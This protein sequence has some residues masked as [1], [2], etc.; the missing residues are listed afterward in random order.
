MNYKKLPIIPN[1]GYLKDRLKYLRKRNP[2]VTEELNLANASRC[3]FCDREL[4]VTIRDMNA[5]DGKYGRR[6]DCSEEPMTNP[7]IVRVH[8]HE[9][10]DIYESA[11]SGKSEGDQ[12]DVC[13]ICGDTWVSM[14]T[15][16]K[17][18]HNMEWE[19]FVS[20]TGYNGS[21]VKFS[22]HHR[23]TLSENKRQ[24]YKTD[25]GI[26]CKEENA[27]RGSDNPATR[28]EVRKKISESRLGKPCPI[29]A[30]EKNSVRLSDKLLN[31]ERCEF[32]YGYV[33][34]VLWGGRE[35]YSRSLVEFKVLFNLL[36][37][38]KEVEVEPCRIPYI[39]DGVTRN[40]VPDFKIGNEYFETKATKEEFESEKYE[41]IKKSG[42]NLR[43]LNNSS[44][45]EVIGEYPLDSNSFLK[46]LKNQILLGN[47]K[48][49]IPRRHNGRYTFLS[50]LL[51]EDYM[52]VL[53]KSEELYNE[54]KKRLCIGK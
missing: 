41:S 24:F 25:R 51:G 31:G 13:P 15:H 29:K 42:L 21:R 30:K 2:Q 27:K 9:L 38:G 37:L 39:K 10:L 18:H 6:G 3:P 8:I 50:N 28:P 36:L 14:A 5:L 47:V 54:N 17:K 19:D 35:Y 20:S 22:E 49:N 48:V 11:E 4:A 52:D 1:K 45:K 53:T 43:F 7:H 32:S 26:Q 44:F 40:Y 34:H 46:E 33:F 23:N 16:V 12:G